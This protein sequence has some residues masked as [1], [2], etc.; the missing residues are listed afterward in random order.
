LISIVEILFSN[1][2]KRVDSKAYLIANTFR[3]VY[4]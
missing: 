1:K 2:Q 3:R 4:V